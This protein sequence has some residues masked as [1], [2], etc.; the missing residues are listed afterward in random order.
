VNAMRDPNNHHPSS[1]SNSMRIIEAV[2]VLG[3]GVTAKEIAGALHIPPA[4]VYRLLN[5][6]VAEEYLVRTSDLRGFGLGKRLGGLTAALTAPVPTAA[7]NHIRE[8][9]DTMRF[10]VHIMGFH[11]T[12]VRVLDADPDHPVRAERELV[13]HLHASAAGKLLLADATDWRELLPPT[14]LKKLTSRTIT[15]LAALRDQL[16]DI[17]ANRLSVQIEELES[18]LAC[19]A[20]PLLGPDGRAAGALCLSGPASRIDALLGHVDPA[21]QSAQTLAPLL[22]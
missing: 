11:S 20:I 10:A 19:V 6:L 14:T 13:R 8:L 2:A 22:F 1:M 15:D 4:T 12:A 21:R 18:E 16:Q 17:R 5:A 9:R 3:L 7:R